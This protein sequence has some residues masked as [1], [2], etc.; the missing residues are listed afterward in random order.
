MP[1]TKPTLQE[2]VDRIEQDFETRVEGAEVPLLRRSVMRVK[3]RVYAGAV[4]LVYGFLTWIKDQLFVSTADEENLVIH[5]AEYGI[6][7][8]AADYAYGN[9]TATGTAGTTIPANTE[10]EAPD[11]QVY[12]VDEDAIVAGSGS[13]LVAVTAK[14]AGIDGNQDPAVI[15]TYVTPIAG[16][17]STG[18]VDSNGITEGTDQENI[19]DLRDRILDRKRQPPHGGASFDYIKWL[20]EISGVTRAW[21]I[22]QYMGVGT[23]G[24]AFVRDDDPVGI[25]P[26]SAQLVE[27]MDYI[28]NHTDP[29]SG[30]EVGI[31]TTAEPGLF[32]IEITEYAVDFQIDIYPNTSAIQASIRSQLADLLLNEGGPGETI[33]ENEQNSAV[34]AAGG[35]VA[36]RINTPG[37]DIGIA[38]NRVPILGAV[39]FGDY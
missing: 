15:L 27:A 31:P 28:I 13:V 12:I 3:A 26:T 20:K 14:V 23:I 7:Q 37:S 32:M 22:P 38:V 36:F 9:Y 6:N 25:I 4:F 18:T 11:G 39:S 30:D 29:A 19:E 8:N 1:F 24:V 33:Y 34:G 35:L 16:I 5:G 10:L 21:A 17:D 2:L